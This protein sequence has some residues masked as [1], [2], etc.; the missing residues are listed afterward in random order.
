MY[1]LL[2]W[3]LMPQIANVLVENYQPLLLTKV[4]AFQI[5][6]FYSHLLYILLEIRIS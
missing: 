5:S 2:Y 3:L 1:Q 4:H 6:R